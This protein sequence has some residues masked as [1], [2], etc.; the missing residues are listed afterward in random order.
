MCNEIREARHQLTL[1]DLRVTSIPR[2]ARTH[3]VQC[4]SILALWDVLQVPVTF[5]YG[6]LTGPRAVPECAVS[7]TAMW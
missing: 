5:I 6:Q 2:Q 7:F 1:A 3:S 4:V